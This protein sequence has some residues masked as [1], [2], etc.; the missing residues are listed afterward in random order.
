MR[1]KSRLVR[2]VLVVL[3]VLFFA[4]WFA[5]STAFYPPL[6]GQL[7]ADVSALVPR[8]VDF[9]LS[10]AHLAEA[11]KGFP[12]LAMQDRLDKKKAWQTWLRSPEYAELNTEYKIEETLAQIRTE[13]KRIPLGKEPLDVFGGEDIVVAGYFKGSDLAQSDWA[14]YGRANWMGKLA[15]SLLLHPSWVG[16]EKQGIKAVVDGKTVSLAGGS[17]PRELFVTRIK[18]VV[19]VSTKKQ[20][21]QAAHD[22][23]AKSYADSFFQSA[24]YADHIQNI[25]RVKERDELEVYLNTHKLLENLGLRG[26]MPD[27]HSQD[28]TPAFLGRLFQLPSV[29]SIIGVASVDEGFNADLHGEFASEVLTPE[30]QKFYRTRG[31]G[32]DELLKDVA[33]MAPADT[34]L[35]LYLR[36][37]IGD[38]LRLALA[39][40]EPA[41][42]SNLEDAFRNTGKYPNLE[43]LVN[44]LD[45]ALK[46]RAVLIVRPNDY[47]ADKEGPPHN[48]APVPAVALVLWPKNVDTITS[49]RELIG[50]R[51]S[52]FGLQGK[53][54]QDPGYF[55]N[56]E[57]GFET[58]EYWSPLIEG[59]GIIATANANDL[60]IITNSLGMLGHILK[61]S[62]QGSPKYPRLSDVGPFRAFVQSSIPQG[63]VFTWINP[64]ALAPI[65]RKRVRQNAEDAITKHIDWKAERARLEDQVIRESFAGQKRGSLTPEVQEQV[66]R[67][68]DPKIESIERRMKE[69]QVP[70]LMAKQER[71]ISYAEQCTAGI[72]ILALNP[73]AFELSIRTLIPLDEETAAAE[74]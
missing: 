29:K 32:R 14:V 16:L 63:T 30:Q 53:T 50:Q 24:A 72:G 11:F 22:L 62:T 27:T 46:D 61:T 55:K 60:T 42:R 8:D 2:V 19:I 18:D 44:E 51:G 5:F 13:V 39:S 9:Y 69:E 4:G 48:D 17:L 49:F 36:G 65:L 41:M 67:L 38:L 21:A 52:Q 10:R 37:N 47:P 73:K 54:P 28:F 58:R 70:A 31:F 26:P 6:E 68:V 3:V 23:E 25:P 74:Q 35:F 1:I 43:A 57:A 40:C 59:T 56:A 66:D 33:S 34:S 7:A 12:R 45:G 64:R 71:W 20:L 15:E